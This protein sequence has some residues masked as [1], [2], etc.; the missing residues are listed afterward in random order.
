MGALYVVCPCSY[1]ILALLCHLSPSIV[2]GSVRPVNI[3]ASD[4]RSPTG[5]GS[6][7]MPGI[8]S[9]AISAD[10]DSGAKNV[11]PQQSRTPYKVQKFQ[12]VLDAENVDLNALRK[13][14][15]NGVPTEFRAMVW[16]LLLGYL[17]TN[18]GR[19][20]TA[21]A[22]KRKEYVDSIPMYFDVADNERTVQEG[23]TLR[24]I[25]VDLPRTNP[26]I[27]YFHQPAMQKAMER[28][29]YIWATRHPASGYV[30]GMN[31]L[32]TPLLIVNMCPYVD[33]VMRADIG[34]L[35]PQTVLNVEADSYWC[36][37][38]LL[39]NIQDHYTSS[40]PGLQRMVLRLEDLITRID[41]E[42][43]HHFEAESLQYMQFAFRWMNCLLLRELP[44][45]AILRVWDTYLSEDRGGFENFHVY[46]CTVL[47]KTFKDK[48]MTMQ[49]QDILMFLQEIPTSDWGE[50]E[51]EPILSQAFILS[52]LF[53]DSPSHLK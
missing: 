17:P 45:R 19:R 3:S 31:D 51:V 39:D 22:R 20:E 42:L 30:Q 29:L 38:K 32:L 14:S 50:E 48:L 8:S 52:T 2:P 11:T 5:F 53:E 34:A 9:L 16:Q 12:A 23:E 26:G 10:V 24:Q 40:Q 44:L 18:K 46:V 21:L 4:E 15:W 28:I 13:L 35:D 1:S 49:F 41:Q 37:T 33:D 27:P 6:D 7:S 47:L 36:L 43:H 25:L